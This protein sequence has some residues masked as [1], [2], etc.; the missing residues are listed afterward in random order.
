MSISKEDAMKKAKAALDRA[1]KKYDKALSDWQDEMDTILLKPTHA[2]T[3]SRKQVVALARAIEND[4]CFEK[5]MSMGML[6]PALSNHSEEERI[7]K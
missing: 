7:I 4:E 6:P 1:Q 5:I 3:L 2:R